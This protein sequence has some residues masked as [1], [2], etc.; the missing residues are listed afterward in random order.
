METAVSEAALIPLLLRLLEAGTLLEALA[1]DPGMS[2][3]AAT[4][5]VPLLPTAG[6]TIPG[7]TTPE[8]VGTSPVDGKAIGIGWYFTSLS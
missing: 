8:V 7:R 6:L 1:V 2:T 5:A 4:R 3:V